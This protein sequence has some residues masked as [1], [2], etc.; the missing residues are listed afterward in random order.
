MGD[1]ENI[2]LEKA[3]GG[4]I[5]SFNEL[6]LLYQESAYNV[7][8]RIMGDDAQAADV[9]Q[10]AFISAYQSL[11]KLQH[12]NFKAWVLRIVHNKC[13]DQLRKQK[14]Q[15]QSSLE[16]ITDENESVYFLQDQ[17]I[18]MPE[19]AVQDAEL[20]QAVQNCLQN[21]PEEQ[22]ASIVL[23]DV[24]GLDY[25]TIAETLDVSVGTVK[26]RMSRARKKLQTCLQGVS[27]LLP[28]RYRL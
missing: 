10:D 6:V 15:K 18:T 8:L 24:E 2:L 11:G 3:K 21:L 13:L 28:N 7:A 9:T 14:R 12:N 5:H 23:C 19:S 4:D 16:T 1:P 27:E 25:A 20:M 26:S 22:R 17:S